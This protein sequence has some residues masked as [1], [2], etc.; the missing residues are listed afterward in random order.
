MKKP[1]KSSAVGQYL[2]YAIQVWRVLYR[3]LEAKQGDSVSLEILDDVAVQNKDGVKVEQ[4]KSSV[5]GAN[6]V[7]N[8][9][10]DLWKTISIWSELITDSTLEP[11]KTKFVLY[12]RT[13]GSGDVVGLLND[14][15]TVTD[16]ENTCLKIIDLLK[17]KK[18]GYIPRS[19]AKYFGSFLELTENQRA[20]LMSN[21]SYEYGEGDQHEEI[22]RLLLLNPLA[23]EELADEVVIYLLGWVKKNIDGNIEKNEL[24]II[25]YDEFSVEMISIVRKLDRNAILASLIGK[26]TIDELGNIEN[27]V[28]VRQL[29]LVNVEQDG[30]ERAALNKR[31]AEDN[32]VAWTE[33]GLVH[34]S[35]YDD[36]KDELLGVWDNEKSN[37]SIEHSAK[38]SEDKGRLVLNRCTA[39]KTRLQGHDLEHYFVPGS[40]HVL[41]DDLVLGWHPDYKKKLKDEDDE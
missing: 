15:N 34:E 17:D 39:H 6:S 35:S 29:E 28:F 36:L 3:L 33:K 20:H 16:A 7:S 9:S 8:K 14:I 1:H 13:E 24:P 41:A 30:V 37:I 25:S 10:T 12:T 11:E 19:I 21:F 5:S 23:P 32:I 18:T 4:D 26:P 27:D 2:G 31:R 38:S 40:Y 22:K